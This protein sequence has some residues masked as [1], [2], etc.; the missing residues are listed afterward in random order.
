VPV[1]VPVERIRAVRD[2]PLRPERPLVVYWMRAQRRVR[3]N[4]ALARA[5]ELARALKRPLLVAETI[6]CDEPWASDRHHAFV[7]AGMAEN[8][9]RLAG[10]PVAYHP[11]V[12]SSPGAVEGFL[13]ALG[14][15]TAAMV[16][17]DV[18]G[19]PSQE[20]DALGR[21]L[22]VR[23][24]AVDAAT[25]FPFRLSGREFPTAYLLRRQLQRHLPPWL[26]R[27]PAADP[28]LRLRLPPAA[29]LPAALLRRWPAVAPR[30]LDAPARLLAVL[31]IDHAVAPA[32]QGGSAAAEAR[33]AAFL[34][35]PADAY[36]ADRDQ[37]DL[38]GTSGLSP[39]LHHGH[40]AAEQV[41]AAL[42]DREGW[43]PERLGERASGQREGWWGLSPSAEAFLDQLIT[44][45]ELGFGWAAFRPDFQ[46]LSSLPAWAQSTLARHA[47]DPRRPRY[48]RRR[49]EAAATHDP[50][51][52]A[53]QRQLLEA[54]TIHNRLRMLWGKKILEWTRH[55]EEALSTLLALND[56]WA[57]DGR[58]PNSACG[59]LWCLGRHDRPWWPERPIFGTVR[60]MSSESAARKHRLRAYLS[61][62][63]GSEPPAR[64]AGRSR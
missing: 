8:R 16:T 31:P 58:D 40:L 37:P 53:A 22:D 60:Y 26:A 17:D 38:D 18:P 19:A 51:W 11:L 30:Q 54:G 20:A 6:A 3:W 63:G 34:A 13:R 50:L 21:E 1:K 61:R 35:G 59:L 23:L 2:T 24:E 32:G 49:L 5:V 44:W 15:L 48:T 25:V 56:R 43:T 47:R 55:P 36:L 9:R 7:L 42:L 4:H 57:L 12:G 46:A 27:R 52:N 10:R 64:Q 62:F 14:P 28:L 33:L 41:V 39:W 45:R 29:P